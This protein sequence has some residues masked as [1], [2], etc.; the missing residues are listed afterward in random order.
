MQTVIDL[1]RVFFKRGN[2]EILTNI[3]WTIE[4]DEHWAILGLNGSGKTSLLNIISAH[5]FPTDGEVHV[6]GNRFGETNLPELRKEIGYVSSS[7]ERFAQM[8]QHETVERVII[9]GKFASFGLYEHPSP[10]DWERADELLHDFRLFHLKGKPINLLS[11]GEKRRILIARALMNK[12]KM[13]IMDEPCSG[14]DILSREQFLHTLEVVTTND[15][16][17]VYVSHHVEELME[18]LTHVLLLKEG[19]IVAS[20]KKEDVMTNELLT[21]T[22]NVPVKIRWEDG[23]PYLSIKRSAVVR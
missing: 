17:L 2:K 16:H 23:R 15:C 9:S 8:F 22:Y 7:L 20:G 11:E 21:E 5:Q 3:E 4:K 13:L 18:D 10:A 14:L 12:P 1:K 19:K 6:L